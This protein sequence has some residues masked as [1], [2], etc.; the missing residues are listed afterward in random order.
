MVDK[1]SYTVQ[2]RELTLV[3]G[4][5][6]HLIPMGNN[7]FRNACMCRDALCPSAKAHDSMEFPGELPWSSSQ[8]LFSTIPSCPLP[9]SWTDLGQYWEL[10]KMGSRAWYTTGPLPL[11]DLRALFQSPPSL[12]PCWMLLPLLCPG[13]TS[14]PFSWLFFFLWGAGKTFHPT[15]GCDRER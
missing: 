6:W 14:L 13:L 5:L 15:V 9:A 3:T 7:V 12:F 11:L 2:K 4:C 8:T 1:E 10:G